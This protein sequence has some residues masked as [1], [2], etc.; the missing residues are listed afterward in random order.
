L[1]G[2]CFWC[3]GVLIFLLGPSPGCRFSAALRCGLSAL[4]GA[5]HCLS[6]LLGFCNH[7]LRGAR[8]AGAA[9]LLFGLA[10]ILDLLTSIACGSDAVKQVI[11]HVPFIVMGLALAWVLLCRQEMIWRVFL[12]GGCGILLSSV[13]TAVF[14]GSVPSFKLLVSALCFLFCGFHVAKRHLALR[15]ALRDIRP[16]MRLYD[17]HW[18]TVRDRQTADLMELGRIVKDHTMMQHLLLAHIRKVKQPSSDLQHLLDMS[19]CLNNWYQDVVA[20]W[21][22]FLQ[23]NHKAAPR[24]KKARAYEKVER[25]YNGDVSRVLDFVRSSIVADTIEEATRVLRFVLAQGTVFCIKNRYD[26]DYDS[27]ETGGYRDVNL[28]LSFDELK[29]TSFDGY[30]F[31]LQIIL[32]C[33][34]QVKSNEG[35]KRYIVCRNL[36]GD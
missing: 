17:V 2:V 23:L 24:K 28:Q 25:S 4:L 27:Q 19:K 1:L 13:L 34:L 21:A 9:Y 8:L 11:D 14:F 7:A 35:H 26:L 32:S 16:D 33:F 5:S 22:E 18:H 20:G 10:L 36:R 15:G 30:V 3:L 6:A 12:C 29:G 31:E